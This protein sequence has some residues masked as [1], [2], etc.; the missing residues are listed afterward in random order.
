MLLCDNTI[1]TTLARL[2]CLHGP[3]P[4]RWIR[5]MVI[6][7]VTRGLTWLTLMWCD[8]SHVATGTTLP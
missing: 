4:L 2:C 7:V 1:M 6:L 5:G 8:A 3:H